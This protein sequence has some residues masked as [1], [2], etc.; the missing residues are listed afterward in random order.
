MLPTPAQHQPDIEG[1]K[2]HINARHLGLLLLYP[3]ASTDAQDSLQVKV[4]FGL[5]QPQSISCRASGGIMTASSSCGS[6]SSLRFAVSLRGAVS[7]E[8]DLC[9]EDDVANRLLSCTSH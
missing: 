8:W 5:Q 6:N 1:V 4:Q 2:L 7:L 9:F 3:E